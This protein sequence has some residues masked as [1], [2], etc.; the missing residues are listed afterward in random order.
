MK[1]K[2]STIQEL[3]VILKEEFNIKLGPKELTT[4]AL[5]LVSSF[6]TMLKFESHPTPSIDNQMAKEQDRKENKT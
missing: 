1:L 4:F 6:D 2:Q 5:F 3:G